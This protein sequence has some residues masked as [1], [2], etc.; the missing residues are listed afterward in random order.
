MSISGRE[1]SGSGCKS[2]LTLSA[3]RKRLVFSDFSDEAVD[4]IDCSGVSGCACFCLLEAGDF[5]DDSGV[6]LDEAMDSG[7][8]VVLRDLNIVVSSS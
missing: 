7:G 1:S 5:L 3:K 4:L 6:S 2:L 8:V